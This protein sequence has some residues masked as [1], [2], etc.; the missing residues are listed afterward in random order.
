M[1]QKSI[2]IGNLTDTPEM[3]YTPA[4]IAVTNFTI[5]VQVGY[6]SKAS[7]REC[8]KGW[9]ESYSGKGWELTAFIRITAWR[10]LAETCG[11]FLEKGRKVMVEADLGGE[12]KDGVL[13]PRIWGDPARASFEYTAR[14]V[15]FLGSRDDNGSS[16]PAEQDEPAEKAMPW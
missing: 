1:Y 10:Q 14:V 12:T 2:F 4:G 3:R 8:P 11:Q 13:N 15:K 5:A 9:K 7:D 6:V 16:G